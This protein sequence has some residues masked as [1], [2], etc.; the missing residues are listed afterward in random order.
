M[1]LLPTISSILPSYISRNTVL[2]LLLSFAFSSLANADASVKLIDGKKFIDYEVT[3]QSRP[4]SLRTIKKDLTRL[5]TKLSA[6]FLKENQ[7]IEV[8]VTN[9]DLP[10]IYQYAFTNQNRDM[11][12][13]DSNTPYKLYFNYKIK[14]ADGS[15]VKEG[16]HKVKE[17]ADSG[18]AQRRTQNRGTVSYYQ[19][20]LEKWLKNLKL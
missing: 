20:P 18:I 4:K 11:R 3:D 5:F 19:R 1:N 12:I 6:E 7:S 16:S 14:N 2:M 13:I 10:G 9:I 17:F 8:E 15:V